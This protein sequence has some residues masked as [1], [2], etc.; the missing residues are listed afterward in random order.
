MKDLGDK[1]GGLEYEISNVR[2]GALSQRIGSMCELSDLSDS[3]LID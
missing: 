2:F 1:R 3:Q